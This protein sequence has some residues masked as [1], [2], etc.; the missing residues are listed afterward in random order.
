MRAKSLEERFWAKVDKRGPDDCWS[1]RGWHNNDSGYGR[2]DVQVSGVRRKLYAHRIVYELER[3]S[4][5][6]GFQ[7]DHLCRNRGCVNPAHLEAVTQRTNILRGTGFSARN[8]RKTHCPQGHAL[9]PDNVYSRPLEP[10]FR[11]CLTCQNARNRARHE[12]ERLL[13][14]RAAA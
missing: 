1:W 11:T 13:R 5:P 14:Q 4:I 9:T 10:N 12:R 3:G 7:I 8:A 6:D 2:L